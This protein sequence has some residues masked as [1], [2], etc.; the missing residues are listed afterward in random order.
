MKS[1]EFYIIFVDR[2]AITLVTY[3]VPA[4]Y[5]AFGLAVGYEDAFISNWVGTIS[6]VW[7][8]TSRIFYGVMVDIFP[9]KVVF[10]F[11]SAVLAIAVAAFYY[12]AKISD[13]AYAVWMWL[14][15]LTFPGKY[16]KTN[17][18]AHRA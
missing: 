15:Y 8:L 11:Q 13:M 5:K 9:F 16:Q 12:V 6:G 2:F 4:Y 18:V 10:C 3:T 1:R 7:Q 17:Y 14:I